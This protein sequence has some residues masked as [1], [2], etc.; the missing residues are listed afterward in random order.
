[1]LKIFENNDAAYVSRFEALCNRQASISDEIDAAA[2]QVI[3]QVRAGGDR[4]VR[5]LTARF[6]KRD[7]GALELSPSEWDELAAR[8]TPQVRAALEHAARRVRAFY[9]RERHPSYEID[10]GPIRTGSRVDPLGRVGIYVPGGTARYPST[11]IMT[12]IPAKVAGVREIVMVDAG[13][14]AR[15]A[16]G[17]R[18]RAGV[19]RVFVIGGAQA[20]AAL[21]YGT[22]S[23][24]R[25]DK[26]VGPGNAYVA[27]AK[28]L[29]FGDVGIDSIAGPTELV[30][31]ADDSVDP[32]WIAADL[33]AQAEH[34]TLAVPVLIAIGA[35]GRRARSA[36]EVER[37]V[38]LL[39]RREIAEKALRDQGGDLRRRRANVV[40]RCMNRLAPEHAELAIRDARAFAELVHDGRRALPRGA[41]AR[42]GGRLHRGPEPRAADRRQR[43]LLGPARRGRLRQAHVDHRVRRRRAPG[44]ERRHQGARRGR[45]PRR[46]RP[47]GQ[48]SARAA[49]PPLRPPLSRFVT[50]SPRSECDPES[51]LACMPGERAGLYRGHPRGASIAATAAIATSAESSRVWSWRAGGGRMF[52]DLQRT[53]G[54]LPTHGRHPR[55]GRHRGCRANRARRGSVPPGKMWTRAP[56]VDAGGRVEMLPEVEQHVN[57]ARSHLPRRRQRTDVIAISDDLPLAAKDAI[58][59]ERQPDGEPVHAATGTARFISLDDEV[60][61]VLLDGE[62]DHAESIDRRPPD[63][64]SERPKHPWRSE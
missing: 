27:A 13:P 8:A 38:T 32:A 34:D 5:E 10:E 3:A 63:G 1:M 16:A 22:E 56:G 55:R 41:H 17:G 12:A 49:R 62:V 21:A 43:A 33:L 30:I 48:P 54:A 47:L 7:L 20:I 36:A 37:Q 26:I 52:F 29:V 44:A 11:V 64:A 40:R 25:V 42:V 15:D 45:G 2:R 28:R 31:A 18:A 19:D 51:G 23:V 39:P 50:F 4:A 6:E 53:A 61:V 57:H 24:P 59:G 58:D 9:E 46:P 35:R 60:S 14:V